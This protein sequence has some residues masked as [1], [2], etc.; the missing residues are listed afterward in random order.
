FDDPMFAR[1]DAE[2]MDDAVDLDDPRMR[3]QRASALPLDAALSMEYGGEEPVLF[4]NVWP[5]TPSGRIEL[6]S[7]LLNKRYGAQLPTFRPVV[8]SY[9]LSLVSPASDKRIT[10]TF[11]GIKANDGTP[12][13][14]MHPDD[15]AGRNL[16]EGHWV[17]VWNDLGEVHLPLHIT[18]AVRPGV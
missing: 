14:E 17:K 16:T 3:A 15:A 4:H 7:S 8:S 1:S 11:G 2:L 18:T 10:S 12:V 13:L 9:P 5:A 6:T